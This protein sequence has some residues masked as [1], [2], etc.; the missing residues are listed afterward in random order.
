MKNPYYPYFIDHR[1]KL[2]ID[3]PK[4]D[5]KYNHDGYNRIK[6]FFWSLSLI[7][8]IVCVMVI[9]YIKSSII[10]T[11]FASLLGGLSS[12][13]VW[14]ITIKYQDKISF[15]L[16]IIDEAVSSAERHLSDLH[17]TIYFIDPSECIIIPS[18]NN[19][20]KFRLINF[21][22]VLSNICSDQELTE[23]ITLKWFD[24]S[25]CTVFEYES[26]W[27]NMLRKPIPY[28][29]QE[30]KHI[31]YWNEHSV[32]TELSKLKEHLLGYKKYIL[33]GNVPVR[34]C[35]LKRYQIKADKFDKILNQTKI[36]KLLAWFKR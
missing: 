30:L 28:S 35:D 16:A 25:E 7:G 4:A 36:H 21:S 26:R 31:L 5:Y 11:I 15:E 33:C 27:M 8:I 12:L 14:L 23:H 32:E 10:Q 22:Q 2:K 9:Y 24:K 1:S 34:E 6:R 18:D 20:L 19:D 17:R 3:Y 13:L 29:E